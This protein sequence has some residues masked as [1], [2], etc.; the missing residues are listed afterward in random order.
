MERALSNPPR[1]GVTAVKFSSDGGNLLVSSWDSLLRLY[2]VRSDVVRMQL[3]QPCPLLDC[4]LLSDGQN[5]TSAG[6]DGAVRLHGVFSGGEKVLGLHKGAVRCVRS[7]ADVNLIVSGS[8]DRNLKLWD[9]RSHQPCVGTHTQPDKI[10]SMCTGSKGT[11]SASQGIPRLVVATA[12]RRVVVIDLRKAGEPLQHRESSLK[13]QTRCV[14]QMPDG[15][16]FVQGSVEGRVA[17]DFFDPAEEVRRSEIPSL[18]DGAVD[19]VSHGLIYR[20]HRRCRRGS[21]HSSAIVALSTAWRH[22]SL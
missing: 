19:T 8:W 15:R 1:D 2:D 20:A 14:S 9:M 3:L 11:L 7:C 17:V 12:S 5:A 22:P 16:G 4:D 6:M 10:L 18:L 13:S 21:S